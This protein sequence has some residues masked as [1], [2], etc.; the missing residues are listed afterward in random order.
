MHISVAYR[1]PNENSSDLFDEILLQLSKLHLDTNPN[2]FIL[3]GGDLNLPN[4]DWY[5]FPISDFDELLA[6]L[7][8][9][10]G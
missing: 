1:P 9:C 10:T 3:I 4:Q 7:L 6:L 5:L 8:P 2:Q